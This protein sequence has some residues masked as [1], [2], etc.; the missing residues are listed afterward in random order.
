MLHYAAT[1]LCLLKAT[2]HSA[3]CGVEN[4]FVTIST[5][6]V[7]PPLKFKLAVRCI[8]VEIPSIEISSLLVVCLLTLQTISLVG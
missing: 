5:A 6:L 1:S 4:K 3:S 7:L 2:N 8:S